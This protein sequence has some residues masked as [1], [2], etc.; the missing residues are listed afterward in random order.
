MFVWRSRL[1]PWTTMS[2]LY[3][4]RV[5]IRMSW[6]FCLVSLHKYNSESQASECVGFIHALV[7]HVSYLSQAIPEQVASIITKDRQLFTL[8]FTPTTNLESLIKLTLSLDCGGKAGVLWQAEG[9]HTNW[10]SCRRT[11]AGLGPSC[12]GV[13][14]LTNSSSYCPGEN[15]LS[16]N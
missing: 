3:H 1:R 4:R 8:R 12:C 5:Y 2:S 14:G 15:Q 9:E 16:G 6:I 11:P 10:N 13:I 7:Y